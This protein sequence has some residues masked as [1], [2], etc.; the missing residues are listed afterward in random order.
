MTTDPLHHLL[1][2]AQQAGLLSGVDRQRLTQELQAEK[3]STL[4]E[5]A[6]KLVQRHVLTSFQVEQLQAGRG[7]ECVLAGRYRILEKLGAGGMGAVYKAR[8]S[9][10]DRLVAIKVMAPQ[11]VNFA[12]AVTRFHREAKALAQVSHPAIVQAYD[13]DQDQDR[14][15][16]VM[17]LVEGT[18][19]A[20]ALEE[21]GRL[22][23][24]LAADYLYQAVLGLQHAHE[25]GL[26]HRDLKPGNLLI[27]KKNQVKILD[28]GLARFVQDQIGN[29]Q[30]TRD[31]TGLGTPDYMPPEQFH[32]AR[33]VDPRGDIYS[34]GCTLYQLLTGRVPFPG[35]SLAEKARDHEE[36]E[37]LPIPEIC[38]EAPAGLV[39]VVQRMM[40]KQ[41]RDR[42]QTARE[43]AEALAPY[44]A[45]SSPS[46]PQITA[47]RS[48]TGS[49]LSFTVT[50]LRGR[51]RKTKWVLAVAT[52]A[53]LAIVVILAWPWLFPG[54]EPET[55]PLTEIPAKPSQ[56][57][58]TDAAKPKQ[59]VDPKGLK[60]KEAVKTTPKIIKIPNGITVAQDG[61]GE[62][63]TIGEALEKI[64]PGMILRILDAATYAESLVIKDDK[65]HRG[66]V[67]E[68]P[69]RATLAPNGDGTPLLTIQGVAKV[70]VKGLRLTGGEGTH[71]LTLVSLV[72]YC[73]GV[74]L[75]DLEFQGNINRGIVL[76]EVT[77]PGDE[78]VVIKRCH[79]QL[80]TSEISGD[81]ILVQGPD[82]RDEKSKATS[83]VIIQDN[84]IFGG[85]RGIVLEGLVTHTLVAGNLV[86]KCGL[87]GLLLRDLAE[88]SEHILLTHNSVFHCQFNFLVWDDAPF[89]KL[90][91]GQAEVCYNIFFGAGS[92]DMMYILDPKDGKKAFRVMEGPTLKKLWRC[93]DNARDLSGS[94]S[95]VALSIYPDDKKINMT[96]LLSQSPKAAD[97]LRPK[98]ASYLATAGGG[99]NDS[100]LPVYLGAVP[101]SNLQ[102][103]D[104]GRTWR[105]RFAK[106][107]KKYPADQ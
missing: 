18:S 92:G 69:K 48:W 39:F 82:A 65:R 71:T 49:Q 29:P 38:P 30:V 91:S 31:G 76:Q 97:F 23:P 12:D 55:G 78:P 106:A 40:A 62:Y 101:P 11:H 32:D 10:L 100:A 56:P 26:V 99:K 85:M 33:H 61:T 63:R 105:A 51:N 2:S 104:W 34:L 24:T 60:K 89:E 96:E 3:P 93:H 66:I 36:K 95:I 79:F 74:V 67:V 37:P 53:A 73:P 52:A 75:E 42:F 9:K 15:F 77:A 107:A 25:R 27:T 19:L 84:R 1:E 72:G 8:D 20:R 14:H 80:P 102:P 58:N 45:S 88:G 98:P 7:R 50:R 86:G 70:Q 21:K 35:S 57:D 44:V 4:I 28:L 16:L 47:T 64:Q 5:A 13:A 22:A 43:V 94:F 59:P 87:A 17:E 103:W 68:S 46:L 90:R 54:E 41:P 81:A 83:N 6:G